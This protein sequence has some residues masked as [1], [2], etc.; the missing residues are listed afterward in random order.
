M[1]ARKTSEE[2]VAAARR[3]AEGAYA[4]YS[5]FHVGSVAVAEDGTEYAGVNVENAAYGSTMCAEAT[6]VA[7]AV[8]AGVRKIDT[9]AVAALEAPKAHPCGNCRQLM[10]EFGVDTVVVES[11]DGTPVIH[12]FEDLLPQSFG[13]EDLPA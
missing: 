4:P 9:V 11:A 2:L 6:A 3:V 1:S 12:N 8:S 5:N 7:A 10:T 13:P